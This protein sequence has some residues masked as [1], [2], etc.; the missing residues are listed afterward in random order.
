LN[1]LGSLGVDGKVILKWNLQDIISRGDENKLASFGSAQWQSPVN[2]LSP[3]SGILPVKL[4]GPQLVKKF[5][6]C[7]LPRRCVTA[8]HP[9][10]RRSTLIL[11]SHLHI[12]FQVVSFPSGLTTKT[13]YAPLVTPVRATCPAHL[14]LVDLIARIF[15]EK[16]RL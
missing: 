3:W 2:E 11:S 9:T 8:T 14:I 4:T 6:A 15:V 13:L 12:F 7:C 1:F 10:S 5:P 16:C